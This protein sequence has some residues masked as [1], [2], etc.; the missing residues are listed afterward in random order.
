MI[1]EHQETRYLTT[2]LCH[3]R[4]DRVPT[5]VLTSLMKILK[6]GGLTG[7]LEELH[8]EQLATQKNSHCISLFGKG[9]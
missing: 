5:V 2:G 6:K 7:C 9:R 3:L 1:Q 4:I 8:T